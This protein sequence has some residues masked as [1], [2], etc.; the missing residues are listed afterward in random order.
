VDTDR[1][2]ILLAGTHSRT[3]AGGVDV[4]LRALRDAA[5]SAGLECRRLVTHHG[6]GPWGKVGPWLAARAGIGGQVRALRRQGRIPVVHAHAGAWPSLLRKAELLRAARAAG[7]HTLIQLHGVELDRYLDHP[8]GRMLVRRALAPAEGVL[9]L[10]RWW[11]GRLADALP[12][13]VPR[14]V[15]NPL[16]ADAEAEAARGRGRRRE[17]PLSV[18]VLT[19]LIPGKGVMRTLDAVAAAGPDTRLVVAGDGP[20]RRGIQRRIERGALGDRVR[21]VG[22]V[23]GEAKR[24]LLR[25]ADVFCQPGGRDALPM[26]IL[27]ALAHGLPVIADRRRGMPELV[28]DGEAGIL[29]DGGDPAAIGRALDVL[30]DPAQRAALGEGARAHAL[31]FAGRDVVVDGLRAALAGLPAAVDTP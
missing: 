11:A 18:L 4:A 2:V 1:A 19:R 31:A 20:L 25:G 7:A 16:P 3:P 17:G 6:R 30:R 27:E 21:V 14:V 10:T 23:D 13:V 24:A 22:W 15:P 12:G 9:V 8:A 5:E 26:S 29:V 28:P